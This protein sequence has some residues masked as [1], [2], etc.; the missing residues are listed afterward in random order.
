M[1]WAS[2]SILTWN[3]TQKFLALTMGF[4]LL[5]LIALFTKNCVHSPRC[6]T[7]KKT[8]CATSLKSLFLFVD[9]FFKRQN[10]S[11]V[12]VYGTLLGAVRS[13]TLIPWTHDVDIGFFNKTYVSTKEIRG[14]LYWHGYH[15]FK[16]TFEDRKSSKRIC[17]YRVGARCHSIVCAP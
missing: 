4:C 14:E 17:L 12:I 7:Q 16:V 15:V 1:T 10:L 5:L 11:D 3:C 13:R 6:T 2:K 9:D 8:C